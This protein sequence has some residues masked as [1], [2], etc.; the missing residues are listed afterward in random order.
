MKIA[1][2]SSHL[3]WEI[4]TT[5]GIDNPDNWKHGDPDRYFV[6]GI[7]ELAPNADRFDY[8][9]DQPQT[10]STPHFTDERMAARFHGEAT[11]R[12]WQM[13]ELLKV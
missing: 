13:I 3:G 7:A 12:L 1:T 4:R 5:V 2:Q 11:S 10:F 6:C 9:S 8:S